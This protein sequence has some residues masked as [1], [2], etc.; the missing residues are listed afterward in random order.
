MMESALLTQQVLHLRE[1]QDHGRPQ[2]DENHGWEDEEKDGKD[3]LY[4]HF[5]GFFLRKLAQPDSQI[6]GMGLQCGSQAGAETIGIDQQIRELTEFQVAAA[7]GEVSQRV[8][9]RG[10]GF[11]LELKLRKF[12][13]EVGMRDA[14][15]AAGIENGGVESS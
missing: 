7:F 1:N 15:S 2:G 13:G 14:Q 11:Q 5:S 4:A 10:V 6:T 12:R 8:G 9:A 3:Q